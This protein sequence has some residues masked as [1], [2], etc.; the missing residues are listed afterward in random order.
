M[1]LLISNYKLQ[2]KFLRYNSSASTINDK[3]L[4]K[5]PYLLA[6]NNCFKKGSTL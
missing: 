4:R 1:L 2:L 6:N 3:E 5:T